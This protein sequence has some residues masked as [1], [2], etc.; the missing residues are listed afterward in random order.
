MGIIIRRSDYLQCALHRGSHS[1][2]WISQFQSVRKARQWLHPF[3]HRRSEMSF[4]LSL[5]PVYLQSTTVQVHITECAIS[6][7]EMT[8]KAAQP[9]PY[10]FIQNRGALNIHRKKR[11]NKSNL[12][13]YCVFEKRK[14]EVWLPFYYSGM[15][16]LLQEM[17]YSIAFLA[18]SV[19][20]SFS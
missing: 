13:C 5:L 16:F 7:A 20:T 8:E 2:I 6:F 3:P 18:N 4:V 14:P 15:R 12:F 9:S 1:T 11:K 17:I 10:S 19:V